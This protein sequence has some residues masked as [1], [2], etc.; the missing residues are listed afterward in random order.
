[1]IK[2]IYK[3]KNLVEIKKEV[4]KAF[5]F[6]YTFFSLNLPKVV[7]RVFENRLEFSKQLKMET[8]DWL[9]ANANNDNEI[10]ILCP[11]ALEKESSHSSKEFLPILEHEFTHLF[12][13]K[14]ANGKAVPKW[15]NEGMAS[16]V[17]KQHK[18]EKWPL[19]IE[20]NFCEKLATSKGWDEYVNY[21]AYSIAS[22]FVCFLIEKYS[23]K[24]IKELVVSLD[25]NYYYSNFKNIFFKIYKNDLEEIEKLFVKEINK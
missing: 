13:G 1:M 25:R 14:L 15:L 24:K 22:L 9:V 20:E 11:L 10:S 8:A 5:A 17:A 7:V 2:V 21:S 6:S 12:I 4:L 16:Y 3:G 18:R 23:F 19:Y